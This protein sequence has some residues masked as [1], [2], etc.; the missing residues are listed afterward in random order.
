M[1]H[2]DIDESN[3]RSDM[4]TI[5]TD[6]SQ[7]DLRDLAFRDLEHSLAT[8]RRSTEHL[9]AGSPLVRHMIGAI[10]VAESSLRILATNTDDEIKALAGP[11]HGDADDADFEVG[12]NTV[13]VRPEKFETS[14]DAEASKGTELS[15]VGQDKTEGGLTSYAAHA[16][17]KNRCG[18][19]D[20]GCRHEKINGNS[21]GRHQQ[22]CPF[23]QT[24]RLLEAGYVI[25]TIEDYALALKT[26]HGDI[27]YHS[28]ENMKTAIDREHGSYRKVL[29]SVRGGLKARAKKTGKRSGGKKKGRKPGAWKDGLTGDSVRAF[30]KTN[31]VTRARLAEMLEV[32]TTTIQNWETGISA[33]SQE[34]QTALERVMAEKAV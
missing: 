15:V 6:V 2:L 28:V 8:L 29:L 26:E 17:V 16:S 14:K 24:G 18:A 3:G 7:A 33:P 34:R 4:G 19:R 5:S 27:G 10:G 1:T 11:L 32:S 30:R 20:L 25:R 31:D 9:N 22:A 12:D 13:E 21:N 23:F